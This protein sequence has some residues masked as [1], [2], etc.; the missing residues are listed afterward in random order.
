[1][2]TRQ[3]SSSKKAKAPKLSP[4]MKKLARRRGG[5]TTAEA[6]GMTGHNHVGAKD[7]EAFKLWS[8]KIEK[9][10]AIVNKAKLVWDGEKGKLGELYNDAK[11]AGI[12]RERLAVMKKRLKLEARDKLEVVEEQRELAWQLK[13]KGS[14]YIQLGL[15]D[16]FTE[17]TLEQWEAIGEKAGKE[18]QHIDNAPGKPGEDKHAHWMSGWKKGQREL[19][20]SDGMFGKGT[21]KGDGEAA[22]AN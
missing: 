4:E 10:A 7:E 14:D 16:V 11:D 2:A 12:P 18:G 20:N 17:P 9:Q 13:V 19:A 5:G 8:N 1:M 21:E 3:G 15:F 6:N 22:N